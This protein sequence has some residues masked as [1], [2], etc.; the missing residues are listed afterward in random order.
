MEFIYIEKKSLDKDTCEKIIELFEQD[1]H[2]FKGVTSGGYDPQK[3]KYNWF[4][5]RFQY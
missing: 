2:K 1:Q 3:K 5:H 4:F